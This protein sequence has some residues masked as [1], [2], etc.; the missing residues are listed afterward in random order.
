MAKGSRGGRRASR[1]GGLGRYNLQDM[2]SNYNAKANSPADYDGNGNPNLIA[3]QQMN[4]NDIGHYLHTVD[5]TDLNNYDDGYAF[6]DNAYQK[7]VLSNNLNDPMTVLDDADFD[8]YVQ[9]TGQT[10]FYRGWSSKASS[11]R[12]SQAKNF[13][14]GNGIYGD[15][16]YMAEG[17]RSTAKSYGR[18]V[19]VYALSPNA[20]VVN[21]SDVHSKI[22]SLSSKNQKSLKLAGGLHESGRSYGSNNGE[23]QMALKMGYNVI[24]VNNRGTGS[25]YIALTRDA[26]VQRKSKL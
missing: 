21:I 20:R 23:S 2:V 26:L 22:S 12:L 16:I 9:S 13:H 15:G 17:S 5:G 25:Y 4:D 3:W 10:E 11:D 14:N 19:N 1:S 8:A 18:Y 6:Y 7:F 24:R